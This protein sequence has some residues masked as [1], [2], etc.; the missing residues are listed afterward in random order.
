MENPPDEEV[1]DSA[2]AEHFEVGP[3][4]LRMAEHLLEQGSEDRQLLIMLIRVGGE[5][6][7]I[8][9]ELQNFNDVQYGHR[10]KDAG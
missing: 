7:R 1:W 8:Q 5:H 6:H 2:L 9:S 4:S 10:H 3:E